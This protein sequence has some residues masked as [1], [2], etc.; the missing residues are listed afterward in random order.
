[1]RYLDHQLVNFLNVY[2][3]AIVRKNLDHRRMSFLTVYPKAVVRKRLDHL[4]VSF[5]TVYRLPQGHRLEAKP[6]GLSELYSALPRPSS[7]SPAS[8]APG[9]LQP[10]PDNS[11]AGPK[12]VIDLTD[13]H[14]EPIPPFAPIPPKGPISADT[15]LADLKAIHPSIFSHGG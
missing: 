8:T 5:S 2:A 10:K 14:Y 6:L 13:D 15:H 11:L 9:H 1:M 7:P 3:E 4:L 12:A